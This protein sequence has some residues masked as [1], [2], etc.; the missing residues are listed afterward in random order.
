[1]VRVVSTNDMDSVRLSDL[2]KILSNQ[3]D[4][5]FIRFRSTR[6]ENRM[7]QST[8]F[9]PYQL[10]TKSFGRR[11]GQSGCM[12]IRQL[13]KLSC[14]SIDNSGI[15]M[16]DRSHSCTCT[17]IQNAKSSQDIITSASC[18]HNP[19]PIKK[20]QS[21]PNSPSPII[22][23]EIGTF[24]SDDC[25]RLLSIQIAIQQACFSWRINSNWR[26]SGNGNGSSARLKKEQ[27]IEINAMDWSIE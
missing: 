23:I 15:S 19:Q 1:M 17:S 25:L 21:Q 12:V 3:F 22:K 6:Q 9:M 5:R 18:P 16:T 4:R 24:S 10:L 14:Y 2:H 26:H 7:T 27:E 8:R 11:V 13:G 20:S